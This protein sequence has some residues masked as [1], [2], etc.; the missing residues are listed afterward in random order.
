MR[1]MKE[2]KMR[3]KRTGLYVKTS[4]F[5][6][7]LSSTTGPIACQPLKDDG[8]IEGKTLQADSKAVDNF[9]WKS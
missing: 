8:L 7:L 3:V 6:E 2:F 5:D 9:R 4:L 1:L